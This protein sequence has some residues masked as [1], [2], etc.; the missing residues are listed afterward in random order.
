VVG[1]PP[2]R[3]I[4]EVRSPEE[5]FLWTSVARNGNRLMVD[6]MRL[7]KLR[8]SIGVAPANGDEAAVEQMKVDFLNTLRP[9]LCEVTK[10]QY[11]TQDEFVAA[12]WA[13]TWETA[14]SFRRRYSGIEMVSVPKD[15]REAVVSSA[16]QA[17]DWT[18]VCR[19]GSGELEC[20]FMKLPKYRCPIGPVPPTDAELHEFKAQFLAALRQ[21]MERDRPLRRGDFDSQGGFVSAMWDAVQDVAERLRARAHAAAREGRAGARNSESGD[22]DL[23][24]ALGGGGS[25]D[26]GGSYGGDGGATP[27]PP[28][29]G[30][31]LVGRKRGA[32]WDPPSEEQRGGAGGKAPRRKSS[33]HAARP[34]LPPMEQAW[35]DFVAKAMLLVR[36]ESLEEFGGL[37]TRFMDVVRGGAKPSEIH[38]AAKSFVRASMPLV[39]PESLA[40]MESGFAR[41]LSD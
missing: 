8:A 24:L 20:V 21:E 33:S 7:N 28:A 18:G 40:E 12:M 3:R 14:L 35:M 5:A 1:L 22:A 23:L 13:R 38:A 6:F 41:F 29:A 2:A 31:P 9:R 11:A 25:G 37:G 15:R 19:G 32:A 16:G 34:A 17:I 27:A 4:Q 26:D 30:V 10:D 36:H 39:R